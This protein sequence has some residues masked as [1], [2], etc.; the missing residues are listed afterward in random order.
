MIDTTQRASTGAVATQSVGASA[1]VVYGLS[2]LAQHYNV[3]VDPTTLAVA[4]TAITGLF[5]WALRKFVH[6]D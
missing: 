6:Q 3:P 1:L 4:S 2:T 5:H